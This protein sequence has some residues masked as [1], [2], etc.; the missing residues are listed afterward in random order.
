M[1]DIVYCGIPKVGVEL[2]MVVQLWKWFTG[3]AEGFGIKVSLA[4]GPLVHGLVWVKPTAQV[5]EEGLAL[6]ALS[7][8]LS[9]SSI[10]LCSSSSVLFAC[11]S[12]TE[13]IML[14]TSLRE[15]DGLGSTSG[16][17]KT[18]GIVSLRTIPCRVTSQCERK[19][20]SRL[21]RYA[22]NA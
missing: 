19:S 5:E 11:L 4:D 16:L 1:L 17:V 6:V 9:R 18:I 13:L 2:S 12:N 3:W 21:A 14:W 8:F 20:S 15:K 22:S 10:N 7:F